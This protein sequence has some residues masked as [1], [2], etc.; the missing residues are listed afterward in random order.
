MSAEAD[1]VATLKRA[2]EMWG[3]IGEQAFET[4]MNLFDDEVEF[5]SLADGAPGM[6]FTA[7]ASEKGDVRRYFQRLAQDWEMVHF[8]AHQFIAQGDYVV[9][10]GECRWRNRHTNKQVSTPKADFFR[11]QGGRVVEFFEFYDTAAAFAAARKD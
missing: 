3:E 8:Y 9:M 2:Y 6:E 11:M 4:W 5:G 1:N 10:R 7:R